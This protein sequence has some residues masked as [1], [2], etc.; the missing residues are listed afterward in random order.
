MVG[1]LSGKEY[2]LGDTVR[3]IMKGADLTLRTISFDMDQGP[4]NYLSYEE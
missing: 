1:R 2:R 4:D 3:V